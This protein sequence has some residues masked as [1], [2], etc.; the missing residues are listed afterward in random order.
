MVSLAFADRFFG[1]PGCLETSKTIRSQSEGSA[2][3]S[4]RPARFVK[5]SDPVGG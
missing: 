5:L 4:T 2:S 3:K 1:K